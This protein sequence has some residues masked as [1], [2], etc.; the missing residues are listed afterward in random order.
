MLNNLEKGR[1]VY[2]ISPFTLLDFPDRTACILWFAGCNMR[3][4]YC[5]NPEIV[6]GKG[7]LSWIDALDF[8]QSR[9]NLLE[10][11]VFSG[12]EC[13][14]HPQVVSFARAVKQLGF[15]VKIDTNGSRPDVIHSLIQEG[16]VDYIALD[17]K[18]LPIKFEMITKTRLFQRFE[19]S[20]DLGL[21]FDGRFEV[22]TT[23]HSGQFNEWDLNQMED[24]LRKK[25][26][27]KTWYLQHFRDDKVILGDLGKS[28]KSSFSNQLEWRN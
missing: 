18:S 15:E 26:Y 19:Q 16:L 22:R 11:V 24:F 7:R 3:C 21:R 28:S 13:T 2:S 12:G 25:G 10:G 1:P 4:G 20:L 9:V 27:D 14:I 17:F 23:V 6:L 5:Y 8:L